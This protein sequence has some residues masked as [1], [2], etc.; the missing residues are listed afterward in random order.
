MGGV[1]KMAQCMFTYGG[2]DLRKAK[3]SKIYPLLKF[4]LPHLVDV[5]IL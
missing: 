5:D 3:G 2:S 1:R 4:S